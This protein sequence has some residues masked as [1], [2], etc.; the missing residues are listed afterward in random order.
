MNFDPKNSH[1]WVKQVLSWKEYLAS[2]KKDKAV[3]D[4]CYRRKK[5]VLNGS[6]FVYTP[7]MTSLMY[8]VG[9]DKKMQKEGEFQRGISKLWPD[10][11]HLYSMGE[12]FELLDFFLVDSKELLGEHSSCLEDAIW[13]GIS[14]KD[15][16]WKKILQTKPTRDNIDDLIKIYVKSR[17]AQEFWTLYSASFAYH[18]SNLIGYERLDKIVEDDAVSVAKDINS[19]LVEVISVANL[20]DNKGMYTD[21]DIT[22]VKNY[23][24]ML[25]VFSSFESS[26]IFH[27]CPIAEAFKFADDYLESKHGKK[28]GFAEG[29]MSFCR[30]CEKHG[31]QAV[32]TF[33]P[34]H[35]K[36]I[37]HCRKGKPLS[38]GGDSCNFSCKIKLKGFGK[39]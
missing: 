3:F 38:C 12:A 24:S 39:K 25:K 37:S 27:N 5:V 7:L 32:K 33:I 29:K 19:S 28:A 13:D 10:E 17:F 11:R 9:M 30:I 18:L 8:G 2:N 1:K 34:K 6:E 16:E 22:E 4:V 20:K 21:H 35:L 36:V 15:D 26:R 14:F 31:E 23:L